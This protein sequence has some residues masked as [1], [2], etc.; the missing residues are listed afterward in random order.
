MKNLVMVLV[1]VGFGG[2]GCGDKSPAEKCEDLVSTLCDRAVECIPGAAGMHDDCVRASE[3]EL[4]CSATKSVG[5]SYDECMDLLNQQSC[6]TL[7]PTDARS[8]E[9]T[10]DLPNACFGVL[11]TESGRGNLTPTLGASTRT[12]SP[13]GGLAAQARAAIE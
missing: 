5:T 6:R 9:I 10:V 1:L 12:T 13:L 7:F 3:G 2:V 8:G 4:S 11:S